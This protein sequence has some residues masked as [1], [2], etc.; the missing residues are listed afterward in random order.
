MLI[1]NKKIMVVEDEAVMRQSLV[2]IL[3]REG[4]T[5][6]QA[7]DGERAFQVALAE[8]PDLILLDILMPK[9]NGLEV[10]KKIRETD[11]GKTI[12]IFLITNVKP[13]DKVVVDISLYEPSHY[14]MKPSLDYEDMIGKI[15]KELGIS[16]S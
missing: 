6:V 15:K 14:L 2:D 11:W 8:K 10:M 13:D 4:F 16:P 7:E 3:T 5:V 9:C 12:K 1:I